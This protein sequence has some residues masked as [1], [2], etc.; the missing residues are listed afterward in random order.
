MKNWLIQ[1]CSKL[2]WWLLRRRYHSCSWKHLRSHRRE[3]SARLERL[4]SKAL[5][6]RHKRL[7]R[8]V[9]WVLLV[10]LELSCRE[11][12][13]LMIHLRI[14][15][16]HRIM[17]LLNISLLVSKLLDRF[18]SS[19]SRRFKCNWI[20]TQSIQRRRA[21]TMVLGICHSSSSCVCGDGRGGCCC[22]LLRSNSLVVLYYS[23]LNHLIFNNEIFPFISNRLGRLKQAES[24]RLSSKFFSLWFKLSNFD[25]IDMRDIV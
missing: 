1:L 10:A 5:I 9:L 19:F 24:L 23:R 7:L 18:F 3:I 11:F 22:L 21:I 15:R 13:I 2:H 6:I 20:N 17:L 8:N 14:L 16:S 25:I 12:Y 4:W